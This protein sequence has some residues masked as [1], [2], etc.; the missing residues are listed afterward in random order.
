MARHVGHLRPDGQRLA[1][2]AGDLRGKVQP[3]DEVL[4]VQRF[5]V[6]AERQGMHGQPAFFQGL[7]D[8]G[9][10]VR[11][12][13]LVDHPGQRPAGNRPGE[14]L[15]GR[16]RAIGGDDRHGVVDHRTAI[17]V[18]D[19]R[20]RGGVADVEMGL[21]DDPD[22]A[23]FDRRG[24]RFVAARGRGGTGRC[25]QDRRETNCLHRANLSIKGWSRK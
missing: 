24:G 7:D 1:Q 11:R 18:E 19:L 25:E 16:R 4:E 22:V 12:L 14:S 23:H 10:A 15:P 2:I 8:L 6:Q 20:D 9:P 13:L 17:P 3:A 5:R 21:E